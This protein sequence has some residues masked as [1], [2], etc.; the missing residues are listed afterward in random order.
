MI[1]CEVHVR[2]HLHV[3]SHLLNLPLRLHRTMGCISSKPT[4]ETSVATRGLLSQGQSPQVV[5]PAVGVPGPSS[6]Q[7]GTRPGHESPRG[8][9]DPSSGQRPARD[10]AHS[11]PQRVPSTK[12]VESHPPLPRSR[13]KSSVAPS[14]KGPS[15]DHRQASAGECDSDHGWIPSPSLT[16][17]RAHKAIS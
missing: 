2:S 5:P 14:G 4:V 9:G 1:P 16:M 15:S 10:R 17:I 13:A 11:N 8:G 3:G 12:D 6:R 7:S